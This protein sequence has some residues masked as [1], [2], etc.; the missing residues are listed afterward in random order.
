[1]KRS[2][3][4]L[5][6][7]LRAG[8]VLSAVALTLSWLGGTST[9]EDAPQ[10]VAQNGWGAESLTVVQEGLRKAS[11]IALANACGM[12][13]SSCF[14]CHNGKRAAAPGVDAGKSPW[15]VH[16]KTVNNSCVG[17]HKGNPRIMKED[18]AHSGMLKSPKS[19][20]ESCGTCHKSD[21]AKVEAKYK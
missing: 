2:D 1:M 6:K 15:H 19:G 18:M 11:P 17:C 10:S 7:W 9:R 14:K 21:L 20:A 13:A 3:D 8:I 16:H 4:T 12:G 5:G